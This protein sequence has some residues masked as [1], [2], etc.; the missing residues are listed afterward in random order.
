MM[1]WRTSFRQ[2]SPYKWNTPERDQKFVKEDQHF[3]EGN[4]LPDQSAL[5]CEKD[6]ADVLVDVFVDAVL[7]DVSHTQNAL[8]WKRSNFQKRDHNKIITQFGDDF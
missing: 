8:A 7:R 2:E 6:Y 3:T 5:D 1:V 4:I